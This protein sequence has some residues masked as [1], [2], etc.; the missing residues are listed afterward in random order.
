M[1]D[2]PTPRAHAAGTVDPGGGGY[3]DLAVSSLNKQ[4]AAGARPLDQPTTDT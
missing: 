1:M 4:A 3:L 2:D